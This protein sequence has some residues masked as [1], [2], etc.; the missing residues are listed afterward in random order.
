MY[1]LTNATKMISIRVT[2][3]T[4]ICV[5]VL[6]HISLP[7]YINQASVIGVI[8]GIQLALYLLQL[9]PIGI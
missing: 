6:K 9:C 2:T 3:Q 7:K 8:G 4:S 5:Y 1:R